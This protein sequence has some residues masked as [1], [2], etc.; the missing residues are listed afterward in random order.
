MEASQI[1][2]NA[3]LSKIFPFSWLP[4]EPCT[5]FLVPYIAARPALRAQMLF[6]ALLSFLWDPLD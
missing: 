4:L 5:T 2:L 1:K 3:F 6:L